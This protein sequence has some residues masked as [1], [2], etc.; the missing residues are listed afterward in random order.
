[1]LNIATNQAP[2][3]GLEARHFKGF[4]LIK[5]QPYDQGL[6]FGNQETM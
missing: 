6:H 2:G 5:T 4:F 1:M 3:G